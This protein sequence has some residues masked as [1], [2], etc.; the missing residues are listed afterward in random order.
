MAVSS[1]YLRILETQGWSPEPATETADESELFMTFDSPPGEVFVLDFDAYVQPS[2]QW[3]SDGWI[4]VL[5]DTGAEAVAV[6]F[7][8]WVVP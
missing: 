8:T 4:R 3:G 7:T 6:S 1:Q 2:S 5:D